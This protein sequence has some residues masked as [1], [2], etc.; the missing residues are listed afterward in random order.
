MLALLIQLHWDAPRVVP[1]VKTLARVVGGA[2]RLNSGCQ[3]EAVDFRQTRSEADS[4][5]AGPAGQRP[6]L[7]SRAASRTQE[8]PR[9]NHSGRAER[10]GLGLNL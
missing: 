10:G 4:F 2:V 1:H 3:A 8:E 7:Q 6:D 5:L 9:R